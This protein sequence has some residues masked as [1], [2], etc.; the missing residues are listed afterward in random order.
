V[1]LRGCVRPRSAATGDTPRPVSTDN[2]E[3]VR[4]SMEAFASGDLDAFLAA[5]RPDT[6]W[7]TA[8]DE[9]NA[10][11][12]RGHDGIRRWVAE[13]SE[14]WAGRFND[15]IEF[16]DFIDLG[17]WVV[18]PWTARL[19]G[20]SSGI[21]VDV[22]ETYAVRVEDGRIVRVDEYRTRDEAI[23]AVRPKN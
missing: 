14:A 2:V 3:F 8:A 4:R 12:Y 9:P 17:D 20:R 23:E 13:I 22:S 10:Q 21:E 7:R 5:H 1:R 19:T 15:T 11:T 16:E 18:V 6:E